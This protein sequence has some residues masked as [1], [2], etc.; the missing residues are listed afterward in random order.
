MTVKEILQHPWITKESKDLREARRSSL[1]GD[2][3]SLFSLVQPENT[4]L[5]KETLKKN[6]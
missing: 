3:F 4:N 5:L 2:A 6:I 1:P